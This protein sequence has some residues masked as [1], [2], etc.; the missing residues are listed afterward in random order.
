MIDGFQID[1]ETVNNDFVESVKQ[2][3]KGVNY[4]SKHFELMI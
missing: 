4:L 1:A 3:K 2:F